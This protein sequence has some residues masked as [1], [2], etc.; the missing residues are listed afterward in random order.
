MTISPMM[1]SPAPESG[2]R[3]ESDGPFGRQSPTQPLATESSDGESQSEA[4]EDT[5]GED[6][7]DS[8]RQDHAIPIDALGFGQ[9]SE[10]G[11]TSIGP[12]P[13][14]AWQTRERRTNPIGRAIGMFV[15][16]LLG[17]FVGWLVFTVFTSACS[18]RPTVPKRS[19]AT[20][21]EARVVACKYPKGC[22]P[23]ALL[24]LEIN[25]LVGRAD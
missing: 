11:G 19:S 5:Y 17:I 21:K 9:A 6:W 1:A 14:R 24:L 16:G 8:S 2:A 25:L 13:L 3:E 23:E 12:V 20:P 22:T 15:F 18:R 10:E 7:D 4:A